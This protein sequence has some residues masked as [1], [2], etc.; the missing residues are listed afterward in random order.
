MATPLEQQR[1]E[2]LWLKL[3]DVLATFF[4]LGLAYA[5][6]GRPLLIMRMKDR[7]TGRQ[8]AEVAGEPHA[9]LDLADVLYR[10]YEV[11]GALALPANETSQREAS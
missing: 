4:D 5:E 11:I 9:Y 8:L 7:H 6:D 2:P 3:S 10:A 1:P